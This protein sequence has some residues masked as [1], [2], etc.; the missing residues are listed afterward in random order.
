MSGTE[1]IMP[2]EGRFDGYG[3]S[4]RPPEDAVLTHVGP[5]TPGGEYWRKFWFPV[6]MTQEVTDLPLR[7][8]ILGEDLVL[9]RD[10]SDRYGLLQLHCSH[11]NTSLEFGLIEEH[12]ISCCYHGWLFDAEGTILE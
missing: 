7:L 1:K 8:Q 3:K 12:G 9:F 11:R 4:T 5:G 2:P 10:R 6:A